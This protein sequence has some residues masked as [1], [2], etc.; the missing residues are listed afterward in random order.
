MAYTLGVSTGYWKIAHG[1]SPEKGEELL[2]IPLKIFWGATKGVRFVQVDLESITEFK[3]PKL[4]EKIKRIKSLGLKF[5]VHGE[6]AAIGMNTLPLDSAIKDAYKRA[7]QRLIDHIKGCGEIGAEYLLIHSSESEPFIRLGEHLQPMDLVDVW[8][9]NLSDFLKENPKLLDWAIKKDFIVGIVSR[10]IGDIEY[11]R[12]IEEREFR[13]INKR[14]PS[15][16]ERKEIEKKAVERF[17]EV[18]RNYLNSTDLH[19]GSE[20]IAYYII[21]KWMEEEN[22]PLWKN[23]AGGKSIDDKSFREKYEKW[24]PAV[25]AKYIWGHFNPK[26]PE[27]YSNPKDLLDK[28]NLDFV[29]ETPMAS[30][31]YET[32]MRLPRPLHMFYLAK[33]I[34]SKHVGIALDFEHMLGCNLDPKKEIELL[35]Y[36]SGDIVKV[37]HVGVP[38]PLNPAHRP[39]PVGSEAQLYIYERLYEL[40]KKG[41]KNGVIIFE[42]GGGADPIKQSIIAL[43]LVIKFLEKDI[44]PKEL[45]LEFFGVKEK[46]AEIKRQEV[47]IREHALEPLKRMLAIPEEEYTFL[48]QAAVKKGKGTEWEKEKYR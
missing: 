28:Y 13:E 40:R 2:G 4:L 23:I 30:P 20:R 7:H 15:P 14:E 16:Q 12:K 43:R 44:P 22:D 24:V 48:S 36:K 26:V 21:A 3:E 35:P 29:F 17:K 27:I 6:C 1:V 19:Y 38:T 45:P 25:S 41:F 33:A 46:G 42:R 47:A 31:G 39:I 9:R 34:K 10:Y 37:I 5:G 18:F 11:Y 32:L 8:G